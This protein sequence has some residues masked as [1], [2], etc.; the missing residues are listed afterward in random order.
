MNAKSGTYKP[1]EMTNDHFAISYSILLMASGI[2]N[3][4]WVQNQ[5]V[6]RSPWGINGPEIKFPQKVGTTQNIL[7][8]ITENTPDHIR[9]LNLD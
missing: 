1:N 8:V 6:L 7:N 3:I 2:G 4:F 9:I 5:I